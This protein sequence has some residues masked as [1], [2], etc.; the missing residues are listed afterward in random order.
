MITDI[1]F[2]VAPT[3]N[4]PIEGIE[5]V[6]PVL[7]NS[8]AK[9]ESNINL[10]LFFDGTKN[11]RD[12][13]S[14][15]LKQ[16]NVARL[17]DAYFDEP[18]QACFARYVPGVGTPFSAI[19]EG[20]WSDLG[21]GFAI[22]CEERVLFGLLTVFDAIHQA[23]FTR[24]PFFAPAQAKALCRNQAGMA[25]NLIEEDRDALG[26]LGLSGGLRLS[27]NGDDRAKNPA[28]IW[29]AT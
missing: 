10:G 3:R 17:Y 22:G 1:G 20:G 24:V 28:L 25:A 4:A 27:N 7:V 23:A 26:S 29:T 21:G 8:F 5:H 15:S 16:S 18:L 11:N 2:D 13:D 9:C 19:G 6:E 12:N 14:E